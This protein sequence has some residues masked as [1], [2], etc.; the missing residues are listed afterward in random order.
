MGYS[1]QTGPTDLYYVSQL[2]IMTT[3][4]PSS[5]SKGVS[6][7]TKWGPISQCVGEEA[8]YILLY[9]SIRLRPDLSLFCLTK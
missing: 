9:Q 5:L 6:P 8:Q 3:L 1:V 2:I 7:G 4:K